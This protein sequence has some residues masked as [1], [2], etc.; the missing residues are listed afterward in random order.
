MRNSKQI[1]TLDRRWYPS[2][3]ANWD[4]AL[5]RDR[6]L[7]RIS[8]SSCILDL[9]AG[10]GIVAQ[11]NFRGLAGRVCGVDL[12][13]RVVGNSFLDE[14][15]VGSAELIPYGNEEFDLV[16]ADNVLE[17]LSDP[18]AVFAEVRRVLRPGGWFLAKTPNR[19]HYMP[20]ISRVTP[21]VFH[22]FY[23]RLRG[24]METD[25]FPTFYRAN[26][27]AQIQ[28]LAT[29]V[30]FAVERLT[31][32]E[33]RPEYLRLSVPTYAAGRFYE[34]IVNRSEKL[35]MFRVLLVMELRKMP[36][37]QARGFE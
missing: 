34:R 5:F 16:F 36:P 10:A 3:S 25:T 18:N 7:S 8:A 22:R 29:S 2:Y 35:E 26:S 30:G 23:N 27:R 12:D 37:R 13:P 31:L 21:H 28:R 6:V 11:M 33:G 1:E 15:K 14:A 20:L 4:D 19:W 17:H 24:R 9:G 32:V